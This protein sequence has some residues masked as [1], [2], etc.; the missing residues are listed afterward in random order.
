MTPEERQAVRDANPPE[1]SGLH[2][3]NVYFDWGWKGCGFGQLSFSFDPETGK[4]ECMNECMSRDSVRKLL[5][6]MADF[7]ADRVV[8]LD[9]LEDIPP[10]D[11][12]AERE[13]D[14]KA[15]A[16]W[17]IEHKLS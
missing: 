14:A 12:A 5:H 8:L 16:D 13:A 2:Y 3:A 4:F 11:F 1:V 7:V 17:V 15:Y 10:V 9:N 6:A